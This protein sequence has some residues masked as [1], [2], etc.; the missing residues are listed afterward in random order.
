MVR[1]PIEATYAEIRSLLVDR[2]RRV[3]EEI[4]RHPR[5][6]PACDVYFNS[7]LEERARLSE[8][9]DR[10]DA[11]IA[12]STLLT[13]EAKDRIRASLENVVCP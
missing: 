8:E 12:S 5:P 11:F 6:I 2:K 10:C 3:A 13:Q 9:L 4:G 7:L 1:T